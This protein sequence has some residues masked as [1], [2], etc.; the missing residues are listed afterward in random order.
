MVFAN[1]LTAKAPLFVSR[2]AAF[3][4]PRSGR[5]I[6]GHHRH[7]GRDWKPVLCV[8]LTKCWI[9]SGS[10][11]PLGQNSGMGREIG[12]EDVEHLCELTSV[13]LPMGYTL[14]S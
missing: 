3:L 9:S 11:P 2:A 13:V 8:C 6:N 10:T 1:R 5:T 14:D 4:G 12:P 7:T